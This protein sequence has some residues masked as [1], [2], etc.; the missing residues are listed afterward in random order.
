MIYI[1]GPITEEAD[2][3]MERFVAVE[4]VL[5]RD[6][7]VI[8]PARY[9][10]E[11]SS[12]HVTYEDFIHVSLVLLDMC[13]EIYMLDGWENSSGARLEHAY[14]EAMGKKIIY[15][16]PPTGE[17]KY[18]WKLRGDFKKEYL[19]LIME[20]NVVLIGSKMQINDYKTYFTE[21]EYKKLAEQH[22]FAEDMFVREE[23][24]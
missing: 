18:C 11:L 22:H 19:N 7:T 4:R 14:A 24:G 2:D 12:S 10:L 6:D 16:T 8:N 15:Q 3:Y 9:K 20:T 21:S 13:G 5:K 17:K 23:I 1:S